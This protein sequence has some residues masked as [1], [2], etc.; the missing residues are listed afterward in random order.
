MY[1]YKKE[2]EKKGNNK[3][4]FTLQQKTPS[5]ST[6]P[7]HDLDWCTYSAGEK[8]SVFLANI[9]KAPKAE[10]TA[11]ISTTLHK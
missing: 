1:I 9:N 8:Y 4:P 3:T 5:H 7:H 6:I 2:K 11:R 10:H